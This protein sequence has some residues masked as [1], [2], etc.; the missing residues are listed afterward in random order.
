M[1][2]FGESAAESPLVERAI[3][4]I[5]RRGEFDGPIVVI[6]DAAP[7]RY[8]GLFD[9]N[10]FVAESRE[11]DM[12]DDYWKNAP[13]MKYKRFKMLILD[14]IS[15]IPELDDVE[16]VYYLDV[17]MMLGAPFEDLVEE[18]QERYGIENEIDESS[19]SEP[20]STLFFFKNFE[21]SRVKFF[22]CGGF[23]IMNRKTSQVCLDYWRETME[24]KT[25]F[26]FDQQALTRV[27]DQIKDGI[28]TDCKLTVMDL[29]HFISYP[30]SNEEL[31]DMMK[32]SSYTN[33]IHI[34]NTGAE[35]IDVSVTEQFV[36]DV[37]K[38]TDEQRAMHKFGKNIITA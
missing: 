5:R 2:S 32:D 10:V 21:R 15:M 11:E 14:Y 34:F 36:S 1:I 25:Y 4:S 17:D 37:L 35:E 13:A 19:T 20:V 31:L 22:G 18:L 16:F 9:H 8:E 27:A 33:L 23:F 3:L 26:T 30:L 6:T 38:L 24:S 12:I 28:I 29:E 7:E